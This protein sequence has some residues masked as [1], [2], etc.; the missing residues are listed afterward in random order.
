MKRISCLIVL[1]I[2]PLILLF[3][4]TDYRF[5][6]IS[7]QQG[8]FDNNV[9]SIVQDKDGFDWIASTYGLNR[10]D[11]YTLTDFTSNP[12]DKKTLIETVV[13]KVFLDKDKNLWVQGDNLNM[14]DNKTERFIQYHSLQQIYEVTQDAGGNIWTCA[15]SNIISLF[16]I[17]TKKYIYVDNHELL[18]K[19]II[20]LKCSSDNYLW[21]IAKIKGKAY[22]NVFNVSLNDYYATNKF[23]INPVDENEIADPVI[24]PSSNGTIWLAQKDVIKYYDKDKKKFLDFFQMPICDNDFHVI[25]VFLDT[26]DR[27]WLG[28]DNYEG[29][30][31]IDLKT[32]KIQSIKANVS[33]KNKLYADAVTTIYEDSFGILWIGTRSNGVYKTNLNGKKFEYYNTDNGLPDNNIQGVFEDSLENKYFGSLKGITVMNPDHQVKIYKEDEKKLPHIFIGNTFYSFCELPGNHIITGGIGLS[34]VNFK[35]NDFYYLMP[36]NSD[37]SLIDWAVYNI[38]KG[39]KSGH[40]WISGKTGF[41]EISDFRLGKATPGITKKLSPK[42]KLFSEKKMGGKLVLIWSIYEDKDGIV[43]ICSSNGLYLYDPSKKNFKYFPPDINNP[44]ALHARDV[45]SCCEDNKGRLWFATLGGGL[46]QYDRK[47]G[48]FHTVTQNDGLPSNNL[49]GVLDDSKG[50][51]WIS[52]NKGLCRY[53]PETKQVRYYDESDGVQGNTFNQHAFYKTKKGRMY[54]G[55][56][57]GVTS[58]YPDS[59][60]EN[61]IPPKVVLTKLFINNKPVEVGEEINGDVILKQSLIESKMIELS[62]RN[63][64]FAIEFSGLHFVAPDKIQYQYKMEGYDLDWIST[65]AQHRRAHYSNLP[66][67]NYEFKVKAYS[68]D[69][70]W[71]KTERSILLK[72]KPPFYKTWWFI[73]LCFFLILGLSAYYVKYRERRLIKEKQVLEKKVKKRTETINKQNEELAEKN[74]NITDSIHY[75]KRIQQALFPQQLMEEREDILIYIRPKDIVSGDFYWLSNLAGKEFIAAVD[76]TGHGVPGAFMSIIGTNILNKIVKEYKITKPSEILYMLNSELQNTLKSNSTDE[77]MDGMDISLIALDVKSNKLE[78]AG[79]MNSIYLVREQQLTEFKANRNSIGKNELSTVRFANHVIDVMK[80][81]MIYLFSDGFEDQFGG[82]GNK[83]FQSYRMKEL[84][85]SVSTLHMKDQYLKINT[86]FD[87]WKGNLE[88]IDDVLVIGRKIKKDQN[89]E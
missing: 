46:S 77:V 58:F 62:Y 74:K 47:T 10:Y 31:C 61:R 64:V 87:E 43:W 73:I 76:C 3:S 9:S 79:A 2:N 44:N 71:N 54:F 33:G 28:C 53:N 24:Y 68:S 78:Y 26:H 84:L 49:Y 32:K 39:Q 45:N 63:K 86:V 41:N 75:A 42:I 85:A 37:S 13:E 29:L 83:R 40:Y 30:K 59:I 35:N 60:T 6:N 7:T 56:I 34:I 88:Q 38:H 11:G 1:I 17:K 8:L 23:D 20:T 5:E 69:G 81:D 57:N 12:V 66:A 89:S 21:I 25:A 70:I 55:G 80:G 65:D 72:E 50:D 51:L 15:E 16:D 27:L 18:D 4:Q 82:P 14:Y 19:D 52:S 67:G 36:D 48:N 22:E